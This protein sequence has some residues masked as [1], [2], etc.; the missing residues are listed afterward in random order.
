MVVR[1]FNNATCSSTT[2]CAVRTFAVGVIAK[3]PHCIRMCEFGRSTLRRM[4]RSVVW[5]GPI[6]F[7]F[8]L[9]R[10]KRL[11]PHHLKSAPHRR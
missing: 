6:A 2:A 9:A 11:V 3:A 8:R 7:A 4:G 1:I 5:V 10:P